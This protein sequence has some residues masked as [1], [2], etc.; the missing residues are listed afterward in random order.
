MKPFQQVGLCVMGVVVALAATA[1]AQ[2]G[3]KPSPARQGLEKLKALE[4]E[5]IDV[6]G[7]FGTRGAVAVTYRVTSAG[8]SVV[9]TFPAK[10]AYEMVTVYH[11]DGEDLVLTH[12][13]TS[14]NQPRM[15][16]KGLDRNT[17][18]FDFDGGTNIDA[19]TTSHMHSA[20]IEFVSSDEIR[21][22][23]QNWKN[24]QAQGS[25]A[26]FHIVRKR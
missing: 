9:E 6:D 19:A 5:W 2:A 20:K 22:T 21:A 3:A 11:M 26:A 23:W 13:C 24:G 12:F 16:S 17:L 8:N 14:A 10:T 15:R 1:F 18:A 7:V 4:G 25:G